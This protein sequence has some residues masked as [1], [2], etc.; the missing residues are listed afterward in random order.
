[1]ITP[2]AARNRYQLI[3]Y[4]WFP[5]MLNLPTVS[6]GKK[7]RDNLKKR[8]RI[9]LRQKWKL[10]ASKYSLAWGLR[11]K[12][13]SFWRE[14]RYGVSS[15][16]KSGLLGS[17]KAFKKGKKQHGYG[18]FMIQSIF[19]AWAMNGFSKAAGWLLAFIILYEFESST[20]K[21]S[22]LPLLPLPLLPSAELS[23]N[24]YLSACS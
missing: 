6:S 19:R 13:A 14:V 4:L 24:G 22:F 3:F 1:M 9:D 16:L 10:E 20:P 12:L 23:D 8:M 7:P 21:L 15:Y 11:W 17:L 18:S 5:G 2:K